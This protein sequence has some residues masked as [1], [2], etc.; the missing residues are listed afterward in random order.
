VIRA[1]TSSAAELIGWSDRVGSLE[2]GRFADVIAVAGDPLAD[3]GE[4]RLVTFVMKGGGIVR[5]DQ[6]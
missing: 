5:S 3:E 1:A 6:K 4:L 2:P